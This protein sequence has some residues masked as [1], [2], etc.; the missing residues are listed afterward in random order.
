M[1]GVDYRCKEASSH[2]LAFDF[3]DKFEKVKL[4]FPSQTQAVIEIA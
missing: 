4:Y 3:P 1:Q 2:L